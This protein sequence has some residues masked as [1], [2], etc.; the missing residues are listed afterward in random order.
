MKTV[1]VVIATYNGEKFLNEQLQSIINQTKRP[2]KI[3]IVDDCSTDGTRDIIKEKA[4]L[5]PD[6]FIYME[7]EQ[8]LGAK[9]TFINGIGACPTDYIA[10][11]DQDD[12]WMPDKI[13]E[14]FA[15]LEKNEDAKLCFHDLALIDE[16][17]SFRGKNFWEAAPVNEPLPVTGNAARKRLAAFSNPVPGCTMFFSSELKEFI[18]PMPVS[19]WIGHD[20]WISAIAFFFAKPVYVSKPLAFYRLH[21]NQTAGIGTVLNKKKNS[22]NRITLYDKIIREIKRMINSQKSC[23]LKTTE[24]KQRRQDMDKAILRIIDECEKRGLSGEQMEEYNFLRE[25]IKCN[26]MADST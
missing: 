16:Q 1:G 4:K 20:W 23:I 14:L 22:K 10:L 21:E 17:G 25:K 19:K 3:I 8:N 24:A 13:S 11:C 18:L 7:N 9:K 5:F 15:L 6:L 12:I 26:L 2:E